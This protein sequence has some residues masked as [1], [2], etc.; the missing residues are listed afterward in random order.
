V[1]NNPSCIH[2]RH[3]HP[4]PHHHRFV[5]ASSY[6]RSN[7]IMVANNPS[8]I[9]TRHSHPHPYHHRFVII[10]NEAISELCKSTPTNMFPAGMPPAL[11]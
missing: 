2:A 5:I 9:H 11:L 10:R 8:R 7:P 6:Q 4:H 1:A 3:S